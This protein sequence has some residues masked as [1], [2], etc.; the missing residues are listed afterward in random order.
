MCAAGLYLQSLVNTAGVGINHG[1]VDLRNHDLE[2][3]ITS[4]KPPVMIGRREHLKLEDEQKLL[5]RDAKERAQLEKNLH[6]IIKNREKK[7]G[8]WSILLC[9]RSRL[10]HLACLPSLLALHSLAA[11]LVLRRLARSTS[12]P[13]G[14]WLGKKPPQ[15][16]ARS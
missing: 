5:A 12:S 2:A 7:P 10:S 16:S 4:S 11:T 3:I 6:Y 8:G 14:T 9:V 15:N 13:M 1:Y